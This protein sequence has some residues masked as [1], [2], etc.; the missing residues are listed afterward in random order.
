M[1]TR[2]SD[3]TTF[4]QRVVPK[5]ATGVLPSDLWKCVLVPK[6]TISAYHDVLRKVK[7]A[8]GIALKIG[9][10]WYVAESSP[11]HF[12]APNKGRHD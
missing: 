7:D 5:S 9:S 10:C 4:S 2:T 6:I 3:G 12:N 1:N 8:V 11:Y